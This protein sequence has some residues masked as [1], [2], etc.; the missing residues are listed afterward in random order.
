MRWNG[1]CESR[2]NIKYFFFFFCIALLSWATFIFRKL[3]KTIHSTN[4][5]IS[6][7][8]LLSPELSSETPA[9]QRSPPRR[10]PQVYWK[11]F[12]LSIIINV[13]IMILFSL[14]QT[15]YIH[16][17]CQTQDNK[18]KNSFLFL[19]CFSHRGCRYRRYCSRRLLRVRKSLKFT[20]GKVS[21]KYIDLKRKWNFWS[22]F[23][24]GIK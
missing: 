8:S 7:L 6:S 15:F 4:K 16:M 10:L 13:V 14:L 24:F 19:S 22:S 12:A 20:T 11:E 17:F 18:M 5:I 9:F 23:T 3:L 1:F 21:Q 2:M